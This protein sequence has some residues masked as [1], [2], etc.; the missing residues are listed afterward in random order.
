MIFIPLFFVSANFPA[1]YF[2]VSYVVA[3]DVTITIGVIV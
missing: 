2:V 3:A 1:C